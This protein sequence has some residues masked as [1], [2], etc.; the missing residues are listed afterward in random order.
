MIK[1]VKRI[2][3]SFTV[4]LY[5]VVFVSSDSKIIFYCLYNLKYFILF[6][7]I[8]WK[9]G[10]ISQLYSNFIKFR[11]ELRKFSLFIRI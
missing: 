10:Q 11:N 5:N 7:N 2:H 8:F 3:L 9:Y 6:F 4:F 1:V